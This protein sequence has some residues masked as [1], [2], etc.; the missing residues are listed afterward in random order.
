MRPCDH[1]NDPKPHSGCRVCELWSDCP[2]FYCQFEGIPCPDEP[3]M[4]TELRKTQNGAMW[5]DRGLIKK[6]AQQYRKMVPL[7][8]VMEEPGLLQKVQNLS[9]AV[10]QHL[11]TGAQSTDEETVTKRKSLCVQCDRFNSTA[12]TCRVCG[13]GITKKISWADSKCPIGKW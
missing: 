12:E 4:V 13:C 6:L 2:E 5:K 11:A 7:V 9:S 3:K 10:V 8:V 1:K